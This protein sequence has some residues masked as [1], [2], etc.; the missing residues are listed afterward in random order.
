MPRKIILVED[1]PADAMTMRFAIADTDPTIET[2]VLEDG[3]QAVQFF[4]D[5]A[6]RGENRPCD[7]ILLD[8]NLPLV[9][10]FEV[11]EY[12]K[13]EPT[14]KRIPVVVLS[15][16][17]SSQDIDRCYALDANSYVSKPAGIDQVMEMTGHLIS[18]WFK[19]AQMA[20]AQQAVRAANSL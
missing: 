9:D 11:L 13:T 3:A 5:A 16:S 14:L 12:L 17:S 4:S 19:Y 2:M 10:G 8:L 7:L 6:K 20:G 18:F 15:G 1:N